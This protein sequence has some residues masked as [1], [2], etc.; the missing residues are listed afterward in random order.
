MPD[1][2]VVKIIGAPIACAEGVKDSWR[3]MAH[4][5]DG[6]LRN[7]FGDLVR[8]EYYDLFDSTCPQIPPEAQLPLVLVEGE[9][10]SSGGKL[11]MPTIRK[12]LEEILEC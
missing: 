1:P 8:V 3:E 6:R 7:R 10:I 11:P 2:I 5:A 12:R 4:W 9:V